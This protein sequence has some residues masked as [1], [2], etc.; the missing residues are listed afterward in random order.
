M[1]RRDLRPL[2]AIAC[3][4]AAMAA[5]GCPGKDRT[6]APPKARSGGG[7]YSAPDEKPLGAAKLFG[8]WKKP[9]A[10]LI[11]SG[12]MV[13]YLEPCGCSEDQKGGLGRR[14]SLIAELKEMGWPV[15]PVDL[16]SL[17]N[18]PNV[19]GGLEQTRIKLDVALKALDAME[20]KAFALSADDL[21]IGVFEALGQYLQ[22]ESPK[23]V[24]ANVKLGAGL[25]AALATS[26]RTEAGPYKIGVTA[27]IDPAE[28]K[29]L[30]DP[31]RDDLMQ[32]RPMEEALGEALKDLES[33]TD[34]QVLLVQAAPERAESLAGQ[35]P[36]FDVVLVTSPYPEP[37]D[38]KPRVL[39]D[40]KTWMVTVG[41]KGMH[42]GVLG[43]YK[44][45]DAPFR[46]Q[47]VTLSR[48]N[49]GAAEPIRQLIDDD[50]PA[51]LR[52][53]MVV[54]NYPRRDHPSGAQF[55]GAKTCRQ[56][57]PGTF[58]KWEASK[59]AHA[60]DGLVKRKRTFDAECI[61]CHTTGFEFNGGYK[62][63]E[64]TPLLLGNQCENCH[65]PGSLHANNPANASY[66]EP[67]K[68][69]IKTAERN[70]CGRCHDEDNSPKFNFA[71]YWGQIVH[72]GLDR[73]G[74][75]GDR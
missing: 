33:D 4:L 45:G 32:I 43:L 22:H 70:V 74:G 61:A 5:A 60:F 26:V 34:L 21:R 75:A 9:D 13:G 20:Y 37:P 66:R 51:T 30:N 48:K 39:N 10:A 31:N 50:F 11:L 53:A 71:T 49:F 65:G 52:D 54:E 64:T 28:L 63:A 2:G 15:V 6:A 68:V 67:M 72:N 12:Q 8:D 18:D 55:V 7:E 27:A 19:R 29:A 56:C 17:L 3:A 16:G 40:G 41:K 1:T 57:H 24:A 58:A 44:G 73:P 23:A 42:V 59:H 69:D 35:F 38:T 36:G 62:S 47:D 14:A 25:D 46:Y